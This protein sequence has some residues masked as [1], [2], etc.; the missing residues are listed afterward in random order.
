MR[1]EP[2]SD[3]TLA[4]SQQGAEVSRQSAQTFTLRVVK[5]CR[6]CGIEKPMEAFG[7]DNR[8]LDGRRFRCRA[9]R[10]NESMPPFQE[11]WPQV[12]PPTAT[13]CWEW[14][15]TRNSKNYGLYIGPKGIERAHRESWRLTHGEPG[16]WW[17]CHKCDN[18]P[19]CNPEHLFIGTR[20]DNMH[21]MAVKGRSAQKKR[22]HCPSGHEY[23]F[24]N[25]STTRGYRRCRQCDRDYMARLRQRRRQREIEHVS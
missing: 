1:F 14:Q 13:G 16:T 11:F 7:I 17:V 18:P 19:C 5:V 10:K 6:T 2:N 22:T 9:C 3:H 23:T 8:A 24:A 21:D 20:A 25:T 4:C 15:G 12:G